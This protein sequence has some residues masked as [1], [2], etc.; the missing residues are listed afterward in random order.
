MAR[1]GEA[2]RDHILWTA[3]T[4]F[5]ET[6]FERASMDEIANRA[7]TSKRSVYSHFENKEKLF[8]AVIEV[9]RGRFLDRLKLPGD[10][11]S[12][13]AEALTLFCQRY[14]EVLLYEP[15]IQMLRVTMSNTSRLPEGAAQHYDVMFAE[16]AR[17]IS[18]YLTER[19][20]LAAPESAEV[21]Q[22]L[23]ARLLFP[24]LPR[25]LFGLETLIQ[26]LDKPS[27]L[28]NPAPIREVLD[29]LLSSLPGFPRSS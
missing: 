15:S 12:E 10:Y 9:V 25:A 23:L 2:L 26:D 11:A 8:L 27:L 3:K 6:G 22:R 7:K 29:S 14:L 17:R 5:L 19:L 24:L 1:R 4:L 20:C 13:P 28:V 18:V 16:V 21:A